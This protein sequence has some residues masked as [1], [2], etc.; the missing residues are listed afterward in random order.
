[1]NTLVKKRFN[2]WTLLAAATG[3]SAVYCKKVVNGDRSQTS[4]GGKVIMEKYQ[5]F[6]KLINA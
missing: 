4:K 6:L 3:Y 5:E 2:Q 1:M